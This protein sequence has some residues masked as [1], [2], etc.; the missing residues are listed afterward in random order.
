MII[1]THTTRTPEKL[2]N[3]RKDK[4]SMRSDYH[5]LSL[6]ALTL[7]SPHQ[8]SDAHGAFAVVAA[9]PGHDVRPSGVFIH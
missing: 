4:F 3:L 7:T 9:W 5:T 2:E 8:T 6:S 1:S